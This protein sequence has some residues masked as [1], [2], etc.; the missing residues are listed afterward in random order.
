MGEYVAP[1]SSRF[2]ASHDQFSGSSVVIEMFFKAIAQYRPDLV[3]LAGV[4]LL[5]A[6][7]EQVRLEKLRLIKRSLA[8][9]NP[10]LPI[11]LQLG[12]MGD[13]TYATEVLHR[14][15]PYVDSMSINEQEL[16]FLTKV[17]NGPYTEQYPV[18]AG[19]L[20]AY[21]VV[22]M[23]YW[24]LNTFGN[25]KSN[26]EAKNYNYRLQRIHFHCLTYHIVVSRGTDWSNLAAGLAA[27][28][29][30]AGRYTCN[31]AGDRTDLEMLEVRTA[32]TVLLDKLVNKV[33]QF[34]PHNALASWMRNET[35]FIYTPIL[36]CKF[37]QRTVGVDDA[38]SSTAL[39]YS[40]FFKL[41][42]KW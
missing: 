8:Q 13:P 16:A 35:I 4:H 29:R 28:G 11:H 33:Y 37:P 15:V 2:I 22:E 21:K 14:I 23:L 24:L 36:V 10:L 25:D 17:G 32:N 38:T 18:R 20:H 41:E 39:L 40:Q 12:S 6:Q 26:P 5:E 1:S 31:M 30:L 27:G 9:V 3:I 7:P 34:N 19:A 42:Q